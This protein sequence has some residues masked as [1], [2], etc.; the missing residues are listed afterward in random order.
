MADF[1]DYLTWRGDLPFEKDPF[2][3]I[4]ALLLAHITYSIFD[5]IVP[6]AFNKRKTL[7]QTAK[8]F[9][10]TNDYED[11][12]NIGFLINK[13]TVELMFKCAESVRYR[14]IELCGFRNIYSEE[15]VE[16]FAAVTYLINGKPVIALRGTDDTITGWKEDFNIAW[17]PQIPAQKDAL[18]YFTEAADVLKGD[19]TLTGHSKGGN[20]VINTAVNCGKKLQKRIDDIYNFDGPGFSES[21]FKTMEYKAVESKIHSFYPSF[22]VVG[23]IFHHPKNFEIVKSEGFAF[24]QHD[25]MNWQISGCNFVNEAEFTEESRL[26]Y[27]AFNEWIDKLDIEQ[28]KNFV[29]TM[30]CILEASGAKTNNEIEKDALKAT[31]KMVAAY[32]ELDKDKR[33]EMRDILTMFKDVIADDIPIFKPLVLL[34]NNLRIIG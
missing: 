4:D 6:E 23:M 1:F 9:S 5:G 12:I 8:D 29:E 17:L 26:F 15:N 3:K 10:E 20:L 13:R 27:N 28:K 24:W 19:I 34:K 32:A 14:N 21:F 25:A 2:N 7:A 16:Q 33:K 31:A 22:S 30:F 11:R 18:D